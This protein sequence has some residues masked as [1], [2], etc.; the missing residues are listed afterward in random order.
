MLLSPSLGS[1]LL[2]REKA[3]ML[4]LELSLF[5]SLPIQYLPGLDE[6]D[7]AILK[8]PHVSWDVHR[9]SLE[10]CCATRLV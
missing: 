2:H 5:P 8:A 4:L 1:H 9:S 3:A 7:D 6:V 10:M